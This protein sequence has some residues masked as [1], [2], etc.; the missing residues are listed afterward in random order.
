MNIQCDAKKCD[1]RH[2]KKCIFNLQEKCKFGDLC[3][4]DHGK[5]DTIKQS[6]SGMAE[7]ILQ[8]DYLIATKDLEIL[9]LSDRIDELQEN[10]S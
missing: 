5:E 2:P 7:K 4:F 1:L 6:T 3:S 9:K 8:L 10:K